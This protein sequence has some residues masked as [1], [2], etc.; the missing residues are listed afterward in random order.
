MDVCA[1]C[2]GKEVTVNEDED[3]KRA[4]FD[5]IK[6]LKP[7]FQQDGKDDLVCLICGCALL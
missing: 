5:K 2:L 1:L 3:Y 6:T 4:N 7:A